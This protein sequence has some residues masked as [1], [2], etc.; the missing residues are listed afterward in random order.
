MLLKHACLISLIASQAK[1]GAVHNIHTV[2]KKAI[3]QY[4][5]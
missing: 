3:D 4:K 2:F 1:S 5:L